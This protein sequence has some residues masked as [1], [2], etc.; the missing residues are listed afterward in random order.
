MDVSRRS[1]RSAMLRIG[2]APCSPFSVSQRF[3][4]R[5]ALRSQRSYKDVDFHT[6]LAENDSDIAYSREKFGVTT[7]DAI[8]REIW[9]GSV[10]TAG[11]LPGVKLDESRPVRFSRRTRTGVAHCP[12]SN[13]RL[14]SGVAPVKERCVDAGGSRG[15]ARRRRLG[16]ERCRPIFWWKRGRRCCCSAWPFGPSDAQRARGAGN[17]DARRGAR[18]RTR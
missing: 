8:R 11:A 16:V 3:D 15:R 7:P 13:M 6:H 5:K 17:G 9:A 14:G 1:P 2:V 10:R 12:C 18:A 4:A